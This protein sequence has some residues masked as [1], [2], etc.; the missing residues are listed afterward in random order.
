[1]KC[2]ILHFIEKRR[3]DSLPSPLAARR[4][5]GKKNRLTPGL[6]RRPELQSKLSQIHIF[7]MIITQT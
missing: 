5:T 2:L 1:M 3:E 6:R 7:T 4:P